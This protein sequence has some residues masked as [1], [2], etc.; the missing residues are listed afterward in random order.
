M[1]KE[2]IL[3]VDDQPD[4]LSVCERILVTEGYDV[5]GVDNGFEAVQLAGTQPFDLLLTDIKMP[6]MDGLDVAEAARTVNPHLVCVTMTGYS[7]MD[8]AIEALKL[9]VEEFIIKP[10]TPKDLLSAVSR[11][12]E[13]ERLRAETVRLRA[14]LPLFEINRVFMSTTD[15]DTL[16]RK[17][18][19]TVT[20]ELKPDR[21]VL[22]LWSEWEPGRPPAECATFP[23]FDLDDQE[24]P[25]WLQVVQWASRHDTAVLFDA[26]SGHDVAS[27]LGADCVL[28]RTVDAKSGPLGTLVLTLDEPGRSF[29]DGDREFL[30]VLCS[31][32]GIAIENARLFEQ[33]RKAYDELKELDHMK[34]EFIS[35]AAHELRTPLAVLMGYAGILEG[36]VDQELK[37]YANI[38]MRSA[39]RLRTIMDEM[40][41]LD[42]LERGTSPVRFES[43]SLADVVTET[44]DDLRPLADKKGLLLTVELPSPDIQLT[45]DKDKFDTILANLVS[46]AIKF[47]PEGGRVWVRA[48]QY[49]DN[50]LVEVEDT[51]VGIPQHE[52]D[53]IFTRFYQVEDSLTREHEGMGLGLSI[54][55]GMVELLGGRIWV[56]SKVGE[57]STFSFIVP[58]RR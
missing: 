39:T 3:V 23:S 6:G 28:A 25:P 13:K 57:G 45:T 33:L 40:L 21:A 41:N 55:K 36:M 44:V 42:A 10:F 14:L 12:L 51:G 1:S 46:N 58:L 31:Q 38:I 8:M 29:S 48:K 20:T 37:Q 16:A 19:E 47:T 24:L 53:R 52:W 26:S 54:A 30:S 18:V 7:T 43:V 9:G 17:V 34:S 32:A 4:V 49:V 56:N 35:I 27:S 11:A 2:R 50:V 22:L 15:V 5:V